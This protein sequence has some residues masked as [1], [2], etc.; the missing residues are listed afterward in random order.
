MQQQQ[1]LAIVDDHPYRDASYA[2]HATPSVVSEALASAD[3][4]FVPPR[5]A[6]AHMLFLSECPGGISPDTSRTLMKDAITYATRQLTELKFSLMGY[7]KALLALALR[8][9]KPRRY[10]VF[11]SQCA[12]IRTSAVS[13]YRSDLMRVSLSPTVRPCAAVTGAWT[14]ADAPTTNASPASMPRSRPRGW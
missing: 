9:G 14:S 12:A 13:R 2:N 6:R 3:L 4:I 10:D 5:D 7:F 11:L 1:V 8:R